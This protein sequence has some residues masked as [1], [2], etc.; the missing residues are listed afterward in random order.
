MVVSNFLGTKGTST[1]LMVPRDGTLFSEMKRQLSA[2]DSG[3]MF[4]NKTCLTEDGVR[5]LLIKTNQYFP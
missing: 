1:A 5:A 3:K 2:L 4:N